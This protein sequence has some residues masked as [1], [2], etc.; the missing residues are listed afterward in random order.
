MAFAKGTFGYDL[1]FLK[2]YHHDL[3]VLDDDDSGAAVIILPAYQGRVMTSTT[4]GMNGQSFGWVNQE[5]I[6][7]RKTVEHM[8]AF[9]GEERVWLGPEGGQFSV[10][11]K[12]GADFTFDN[13]FVPAAFDTEAFDVISV[14]QSQARFKKAM[15][16]ENYSGNTFDLEIDRTISLWDN[17]GI[18]NLLGMVIP[19]GIK[20][21]GF[22]TVN[23][24]T[25]T[26]TNAWDKKY[27]MLSI[28]ILCMMN[29]SDKTN[30]AIP[31]KQGDASILGKIVTDDYFGKVPAE[32]LQAA[33]GLIL[34]KADANHRS[35]IGISPLRAM[36]L[37]VS[38]DATNQV[39]TVTQF[40]LQEGITDYVNSLWQIQEEPFAGDAVNAYNDG[41]INGSQMGR[42]YEIES[43]SPAAALQPGETMIHRNAV[44]HFTGDKESLNNISMKLLGVAVDA[45]TL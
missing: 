14:S 38:Y 35:K 33:N 6:A 43:S 41:P 36:P 20:A 19:Q 27:G 2:Q 13:W 18:E 21:V 40:S 5:L 24:L 15:R 10:Y 44:I 3:I 9:G 28:W 31:Y 23:G 11:F 22:E 32:R 45:I 17:K 29:A 12:K 26:G 34:F 16:L 7:S 30:V 4:D 42:F 25:N 8:N 1:D 39:L 37:A